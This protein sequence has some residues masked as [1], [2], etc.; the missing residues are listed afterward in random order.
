MRLLE[1]D[2]TG[3]VRL[4]EDL[5]NN[6]IPPVELQEAINSMFRWYRNATKC[7]TYL[8]DVSVSSSNADDKSWE[9]AF[10]ASRWFTR[11]WTLQELIAPTSVEFFSREGAR[12]GDRITLERVIHDMTGIPLKVLQGGTLSDFSVNDRMA[13]IEKRTTTREEDMVYSLFGIFDVQ[14]PLIY[15]E[16]KQKAFRRLREEINKESKVQSSDY[17]PYRTSFSLQG[18]PV[19]NQFVARPSVTAELEECLLP[20]RRSRETQRRIFVLYG[21]GGIGKTQLAADFARRH[22]AVFSSVFWLDGRSEDRLRQS[23]ASC[24]ARI[25]E[26]QVS[27]KSRNA[28]LHSEED[29]KTLVAD[30]LDWLAQPDNSDWLLIF[31]N[32]DQD[33]HQGSETGA[34]DVR[35]YLPGDH[36]SVL[37]TTR[38]SRLAQL[39]KSK[40]LRG[41]DEQLAKAIFQQWHGAEGALDEAGRELLGLLDGLP[42]ALAQAASYIRETGLDNASYVR[43]YKQQWDDLM[44]SDGESGSP[45]VDY[46]QGSVA[47]TWTV[48]F[49]AVEAQNKNA[50]NL[51]RLWA[52]VDGRDLWHG[53]LQAAAEGGE[54][55]PGWLCDVA[56][57]EVRYLDAV[58]LLLRYS[59]I[60][61]QESVQGSHT[62]HPVVYRW[63]SHIQDGAEKREVLRLAV[64]VVGLSVPSST[65]KDYWIIQR[66]LLPHAERCS[67]WMAEI[68]KAR[69]SFD[70]TGAI[71]AM[72]MLGILYA[73]QGR[74]TEAKSMC[75]RALEGYKKALGRD[76]TSTLNTV[77]NLGRLYRDQG[78]LTEAESMYQR[79]LEGYEKALGRDHTSTLDTV[80][81]LGNLYTDQGRLTEA[82]SMYQ[83]YNS[84]R[85]F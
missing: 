40:R 39:G 72:T 46:E 2:D 16:G 21:L 49:K 1:R 62:M 65:T 76:H 42:L 29:L 85:L 35:R 43:L 18:V 5:P 81:N 63:A 53:L 6:K 27:E 36:G 10:R 48:S 7:Y 22:Q 67:W 3:E 50:A 30:V 14:L 77:N 24:A 60:E 19:S 12:L 15:S 23:L 38:L 75:Q 32:V 79:A 25:P 34:Y 82:E 66:R 44:G 70:D 47:T 31:D 74:L 61:S 84:S 55:W 58:R 51:L 78:R 56:G 41:V 11:G 68:Y 69:H 37:I 57:N 83:H 71:D 4:T 80:N 9:P 59:M 52:F 17:G 45:L 13:W 28:V 33:V 8:V 20:R 26:G 73:D 64:M 54:Q